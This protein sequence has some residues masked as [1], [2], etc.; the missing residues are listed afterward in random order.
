M[1]LVEFA[2][3]HAPDR[4]GHSKSLKFA[5]NSIYLCIRK[6]VEEQSPAKWLEP[7]DHL[8][9]APKKPAGQYTGIGIV[10]GV[11]SAL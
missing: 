5:E 3:K 2:G 9:V 11:A 7:W 1:I 10:N 4:A 6:A 8:G